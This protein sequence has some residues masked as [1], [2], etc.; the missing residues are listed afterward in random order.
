MKVRTL[1]FA[2]VALVA[3]GGFAAAQSLN[4][5]DPWNN[6]T[7]T[8]LPCSAETG[9]H[10]VFNFSEG[11][12]WTD[13]TPTSPSHDNASKFLWLTVYNP[14]PTAQTVV[15]VLYIDPSSTT[16]QPIWWTASVPPHTRKSW[17]L[18][19][20][21]HDDSQNIQGTVNLATDVFFDVAGAASLATWEIVFNPLSIFVPM[22][23]VRAAYQTGHTHCVT[24]ATFPPTLPVVSGGTN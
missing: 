13:I 18:N 3:F 19:K 20:K 17:L 23:Y 24:I 9:A 10:Q 22:D 16:Y 5:G 8:Y 14:M 2:V 11:T 15:V 1:V 6:D 21:L 4:N 12:A 7:V